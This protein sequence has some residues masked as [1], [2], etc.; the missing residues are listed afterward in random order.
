MVFL[1]IAFVVTLILILAASRAI[2][3][4]LMRIVGTPAYFF[5]VWPGVV[6][7]ELSHFIGALVTFTPIHGISLIP[8]E[9]VQGELLLGKVV[10]ENTRNP[11]KKVVIAGAPFIGGAVTL[12]VFL[13]AFSGDLTAPLITDVLSGNITA[14]AVAWWEF[15]KNLGRTFHYRDWTHWVFVYCIFSISSQLAPS[16]HDLKY[17]LIGLLELFGVALVGVFILYVAGIHPSASVI[18]W[19]TNVIARYVIFFGLTAAILFFVAAVMG[20]LMFINSAARYLAGAS[21][22]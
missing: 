8:E 3:A 21:R 11:F 7:H 6:I 12:W 2:S 9:G 4:I 19:I 18:L 14:Y 13:Q 17:A 20:V 22:Y 15:I 16:W 1:S 5:I 10:H